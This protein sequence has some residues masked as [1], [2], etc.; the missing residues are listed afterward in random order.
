MPKSDAA[1]SERDV[2]L[3]NNVRPDCSQSDTDA[4]GSGQVA[5]HT[6]GEGPSHPAPLK[7]GDDPDAAKLEASKAGPGRTNDRMEAGLS[8]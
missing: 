3:R 4:A 7:S 1:L 6:E 2:D 5:L 8:K